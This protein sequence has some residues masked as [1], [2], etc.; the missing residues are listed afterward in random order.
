VIRIPASLKAASKEA[1]R[2][3]AERAAAV[4]AAAQRGHSLVLVYHRVTTDTHP[5]SDRL[6][7]VVPSVDAD[8]LRRHLQALGDLGEVVELASLLDRPTTRSRPRFAVSFDDDY[9][10]HVACALPVLRDLRAP[11]TF[12]LSGRALHG[13]GP[14]WWERLEALVAR[15]GMNA[16]THILGIAANT[17]GA[18]ATACETNAVARRRLDAMAPVGSARPLQPVEIRA[19]AAAG[20]T[21]GFHTVEHPLLPSLDDDALVAALI[22]GRAELEAVVERQIVLFAYPHGKTDPRVARAACM[23]GYRAAWTG[24]PGPVRPTADQFLLGRWEPGP[25]DVDAFVSALAVHLHR[26]VP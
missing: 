23:A 19:L 26:S 18:L 25:L 14:Y 4:R 15:Y 10:S 2:R 20:M 7:E 17:P 6:D 8:C 16:T 21:I 3:P 12:F 5:V 13:L 24:Q 22:K 9:P 11:A 1:L